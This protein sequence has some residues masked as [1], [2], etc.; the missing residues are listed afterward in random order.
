MQTKS[1]LEKFYDTPDP[2]GYER[3]GD[4]EIRRWRIYSAVSLYNWGR[5]L[6]IGAGEGFI[7]KWFDNAEALE[8]SDKAA[9]RLPHYIKRVKKPK[10]KYGLILATGVLYEQYDYEHMREIIKRCA[11]G[12]V[13][14]CHYDKAGKAHDKFRKEQV[15]Y[16]EFP[17]RD[18]KQT[19]RLYKW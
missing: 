19:L 11:D 18:G 4:D 15:F 9:S 1:D 13:L 7:T 6:D 8:L 3:S 10:G 5:V 14:T 12:Y 2:W 17:Y 16:A